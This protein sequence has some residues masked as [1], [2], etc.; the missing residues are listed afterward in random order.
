MRALALLAIAASP[1]VFSFIVD[2]ARLVTTG[3][4]ERAIARAMASG[5]HIVNFT[6]Y[7]DR[8]IEKSLAGMRPHHADVL[9]LGASRIQMLPASTFPGQEYVNAAMSGATLDDIIAVYGL[10]DVD[11]RRPSHVVIAVDPWS[12]SYSAPLG[13]RSLIFERAALLKRLGVS[14]SPWAD[15]YARSKA[16]L[17]QLASPEYFRLSAQSFKRSGLTSMRWATTTREQNVPMTKLAN[18]SVVWPVISEDSAARTTA[19]YLRHG[20]QEDIR[21]QRLAERLPRQSDVLER[22]VRYL[23]KGGITVT[24]VLVPYPPE[25]YSALMA[26][27]QNPVRAVERSLRDMASRT[28]AQLIGSYDPAAYGLTGR[29]YFDESHLRPGPLSRLVSSGR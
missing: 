20:L 23:R 15:R 27:E 17:T 28:G 7:N 3:R 19:R 13:W 29:D 21:F 14:T 25:V 16:V 11:G 24:L 18:G 26:L 8:A 12:Q 22:F 6:V 10:Y 2:P 9:V 5:K 4:T 1:V